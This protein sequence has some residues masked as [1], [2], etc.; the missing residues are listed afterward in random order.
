MDTKN[1]VRLRVG[2]KN[3]NNINPSHRNCRL[4]KACEEDE[5]EILARFLLSR[6]VGAEWSMLKYLVIL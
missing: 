6:G 5:V 2:S 3:Y 4:E 1:G